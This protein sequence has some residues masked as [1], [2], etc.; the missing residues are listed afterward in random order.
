MAYGGYR[1]IEINMRLIRLKSIF[2]GMAGLVSFPDTHPKFFLS[3][4]L[5]EWQVLYFFR[6]EINY[7]WSWILKTINGSGFSQNKN[8][9]LRKAN[10]I[11]NAATNSIHTCPA[12]DCRISVSA[13]NR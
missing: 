2:S 9:I 12:F 11:Q 5:Y 4:W 6:L 8:V 10:C 3:D 1:F 13:G 7:F